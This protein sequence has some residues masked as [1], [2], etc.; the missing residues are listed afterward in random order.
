[1]DTPFSRMTEN[2]DARPI[3]LQA[4]RVGTVNKIDRSRQY[5]RAD[6][7]ELLRSLNEA[8]AKIR[9]LETANNSKDVEI[10]L[11]AAKVRNYRIGYTTLIA[12]ITGLA[13]EGLKVFAPMLLRYL[14][15]S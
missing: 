3:P 15:L 1:M 9:R 2:A 12:I 4:Q 8:W 5:T 10:G 7:I 14:G 6:N 11:M 13:W